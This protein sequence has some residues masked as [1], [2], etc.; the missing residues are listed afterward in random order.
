VHRRQRLIIDLD[1]LERVFRRALI[2]RR[3][4]HHG[5]A[6]IANFFHGKYRLI[7]K[8]RTEVRVD[9]RHLRDF[10]ASQHNR[11]AAQRLGLRFLDPRDPRMRIRAAQHGDMQHARHFDVA[12]V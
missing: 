11:D 12:D 5:I 3:H 2:H 7:A 8:R 6:G 10:R 1:Q 9:P 4:R